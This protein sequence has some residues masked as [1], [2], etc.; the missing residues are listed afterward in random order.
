MAVLW[1]WKRSFVAH[2]KIQYFLF[3]SVRIPQDQPMTNNRAAML[4]SLSAETSAN[5]LFYN[6]FPILGVPWEFNYICFRSVIMH[7]L[8]FGIEI[9]STMI[10]LLSREIVNNFISMCLCKSIGSMKFQFFEIWKYM[11]YNLNN[12]YISLVIHAYFNY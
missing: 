7:R 4:T 3:I 2:V 6:I 1:I 12:S 11:L 10:S 8:A 5:F 9:L